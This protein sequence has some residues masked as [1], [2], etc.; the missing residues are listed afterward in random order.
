[1]NGDGVKRLTFVALLGLCVCAAGCVRPGGAADGAGSTAAEGWVNFRLAE[2][3]LALRDFTAALASAEK[4]SDDYFQALF[5]LANVWN[6]RRPNE[7]LTKARALYR[8]IIEEAPDHDLAAWSTLALVRLQHVVP[9]GQEPDYEA[10]RAG[11]RA[12]IEKFPGH[13]AAKEATIYLNA[14]L[15]ATLDP[16]HTRAAVS[17]LTAF[18]ASGTKEFLQPAWSLLAVSYTTLDQPHKRLEAEIRAFEN[19]EIDPANPFNE[20]AWAY[21]NI[22]TIAEFEVGDFDLARGYYRRLIEEYPADIR[23]YPSQEALARMD[24]IEAALRE[25]R[26]PAP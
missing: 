25:G 20:F 13:L 5:G 16:V 12:L 1:M 7:D 4:G 18:I 11:Y 21:W 24:R 19:T 9:V 15:V 8:R 14:T 26:E 10:V 3:D 2:Y 23:V 17:N 6:L 22:A